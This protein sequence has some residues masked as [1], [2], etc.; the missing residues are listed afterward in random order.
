MHAVNDH[1]EI[2]KIAASAMEKREQTQSYEAY[3]TRGNLLRESK[4]E[5]KYRCLATR[6]SLLS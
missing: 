3:L 4:M 1:T 5:K 6:V 2:V